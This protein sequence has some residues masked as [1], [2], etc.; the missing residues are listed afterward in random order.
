VRLLVG[1]GVGILMGE[2]AVA[3]V[4]GGV[5]TLALGV[6]TAMLVAQLIDGSRIVVAQAAVSAILITAFG[7]PAE[8]PNRLVEALIGAGVALVFSQLLFSP[9][10]MKLLRRAETAVLSGLAE[11]LRLSAGALAR[12]DDELAARSLTRL[13]GLRGELGDLA[14]ARKASDRIVRHSATWRS[15][16]GLVVRE[17]ESA[18]QLDLLAGSCLMLARTAMATT[19]EQRTTLAVGV[20]DLAHA[21]ADLAV[22][23]GDR[24][25]RQHAA[26]RALELARWITEHAGPVE[27]QSALA[28]ACGAVRMVALDVMIFAG[29]EAGEAREAM[30]ATVEDPQVAEPPKPPRRPWPRRLHRRWL[31][32]WP[33]RR[34][35]LWRRKRR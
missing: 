1:V 4:G 2:L 10:P 20:D 26:D 14:T 24:A 9:E 18:D 8:G 34:P 6:F 25:N 3:V 22:Q 35:R 29:V 13:R 12:N 11:A 21:I 30:H 32:L 16:S 7:D 31:S 23:P 15:R 5:G 17:R 19:P 27:A 33:P 28:A